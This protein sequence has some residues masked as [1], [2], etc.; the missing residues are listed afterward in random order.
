M[1]RQIRSS[2]VA[3]RHQYLLKLSREFQC[4]TTVENHCTKEQGTCERQAGLKIATLA[5]N[6]KIWTHL[7]MPGNCSLCILILTQCLIS[8]SIEYKFIHMYFNILTVL[9]L[10]ASKYHCLMKLWSQ[11]DHFLEKP[12]GKRLGSLMSQDCHL[13]VTTSELQIQISTC[14]NKAFGQVAVNSNNLSAWNKMCLLVKVPLPFLN[15]VWKYVQDK[16]LRLNWTY[17]GKATSWFYKI[18]LF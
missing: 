9:F 13:V 18:N 12:L 17:K 3:L 10:K 16:L 7:K 2:Q 1:P 14:F 4:A 8:L 11:C 15:C 5:Q 6:K